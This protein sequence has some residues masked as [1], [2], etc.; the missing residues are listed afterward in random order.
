MNAAIC[1]VRNRS[2]TEGHPRFDSFSC[3]SGHLVGRQSINAIIDELRDNGFSQIRNFVDP[4]VASGLNA[5]VSDMSGA[6]SSPATSYQSQH[7]WQRDLDGGPRYT[8]NQE[9]IRVNQDI[10]RVALNGV[11]REVARLYLGCSPILASTQ[12]WTTRPPNTFSPEVLSEAAM[13][14]HCDADYFG[15]LKFFVL[16]TDVSSKNGPFTFIG[17]SHRGVRHVAGRM[18]DTEVVLAGDVIFHG[19]GQAGDLI[20]AD[21]KGWHKASPPESGYRTLLQVVYASSLLGFPS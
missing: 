9:E 10:E 17:G 1:W 3:P 2:S 11:I 4:L 16:L 6:T 20:I 21:T 15:F 5:I 12:A 18:S 14:F 8:M 19:T 7:D 13:A